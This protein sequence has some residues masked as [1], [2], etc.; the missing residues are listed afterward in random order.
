[1]CIYRVQGGCKYQ[2]CTL[3]TLSDKISPMAIMFR[4]QNA[5]KVE[6]LYVMRHHKLGVPVFILL[7]ICMVIFWQFFFLLVRLISKCNEYINNAHIHDDDYDELLI[8]LIEI[9]RHQ[10]NAILPTLQVTKQHIIIHTMWCAL[11]VRWKK[12][13]ISCL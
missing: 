10:I 2:I 11:C 8:S 6:S 5:S 7:D 12:R 1:M 9:T 4:T 3:I 13:Y